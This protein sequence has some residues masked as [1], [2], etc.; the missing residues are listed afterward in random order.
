MKNLFR[1][2]LVIM[3]GVGLWGCTV[4]TNVHEFVLGATAMCISGLMFIITI[5]ED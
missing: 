1:I 5:K 3:S 4:A 2:I